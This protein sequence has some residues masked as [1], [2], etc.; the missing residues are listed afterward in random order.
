MENDSYRVYQNDVTLTYSGTDTVTT[1]WVEIDWGGLPNDVS[2]TG[3]ESDFGIYES[4]D[5]C[6]VR[7][8]IENVNGQTQSN[9]LNYDWNSV[10]YEDKPTKFRF[11]IEGKDSYA[12]GSVSILF[13]YICMYFSY[14]DRK[15]N[16]T[17]LSQDT[18]KIS[19]K[20]GFDRCTAVFRS[21]EKLQ[22]WEAR[23]DGSERPPGYPVSAWD[24][25]R[26]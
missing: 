20:T 16:I 25:C 11:E 8:V 17:V 14:T 23:A 6:N 9:T 22:S 18:S 10:W 24:R 15:P 21:D 13:F 5:N 3:Y 12:S 4:L 7:M 26:A 2:I 1:D 19:S